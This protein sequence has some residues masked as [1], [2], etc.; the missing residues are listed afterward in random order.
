LHLIPT[1]TGGLEKVNALLPIDP[2]LCS[3]PLQFV[4]K[5]ELISDYLLSSGSKAHL[6]TDLLA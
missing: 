2:K 4:L 3:I 5:P 1:S 6:L